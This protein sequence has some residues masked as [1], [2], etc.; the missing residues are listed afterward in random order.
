MLLSLAEY[1]FEI[2]HIPG[3]RNVIA[4]YGTR[5]IKVTEWDKPTAD[6]PEG[7]HELMVMEEGENMFSTKQMGE[8]DREQLRKMSMDTRDERG[9][10]LV[11]HMGKEY[12]WIPHC[13]RRALFWELHSKLHEG[14]TKMLEKLREERIYWPN[15][16]K[17]IREF[18]SQC[19]CTIKKDDKPR[20]YTEKVRITAKQSLHILARDLYTYNDEEYFTAICIFSTY[21][22]AKRVKNKEA[23]T[24]L[25]AY[26]EFCN[27]HQEPELISCDN[28]PEFGMIKTEKID[29]PSF[30]PQA[31]GV[32]ERL[33]RELGKQC[34][35][36]GKNPEEIMEILNTV[37]ANNM[38]KEFLQNEFL[39]TIA[40]MTQCKT[41]EFVYNDLLWRHVNRRS[42]GKHED[43]YTGPHRVMQRAGR[44]SY[45][46]TS[47]K[48]ISRSIQVNVNDM[49]K[50]SI[51]DT[52]GWRIGKKHFDEAVN[53][54][55]VEVKNDEVMISFQRID[56]MVQDMIDGKLDHIQFFVI[57]DWPCMTWYKRLHQEI[58]AEA[59]KLKKEEDVLVDGKNRPLGKFAW[60][61]WLFARPIS[62]S[63]GK[64]EKKVQLTVTD[65]EIRHDVG[66]ELGSGN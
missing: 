3:I 29:N 56:A 41:R 28:G 53:E 47:H 60:E 65:G 33:H 5:Q 6:D 12:I 13:N 17:E 36:H 58:E 35:I 10:L 40:T 34:R 42:R 44:F 20:A 32:L 39:Q 64:K 25:E 62:G 50:F 24:I 15:A 37:D 23:T 61:N 55:R 2:K 30:H 45:Y 49:K 66:K 59:I 57:P 22:W 14:I 46:I 8:K 31:N 38:M 21:S 4:D 18:L 9:V 54:L 63:K 52:T 48:N 43:T 27:T 26:E 11:K 7:L 51:P 16:D 1:D 19:V